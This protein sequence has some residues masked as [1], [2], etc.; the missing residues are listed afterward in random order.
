[1]GRFL[2]GYKLCLDAAS[3]ACVTVRD[4]E[5]IVGVHPRAGQQLRFGLFGYAGLRK[6]NHS[7]WYR[8]SGLPVSLVWVLA[9]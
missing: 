1:M 9:H 8:H 6:L 3:L 5:K 7:P 2:L 4:L